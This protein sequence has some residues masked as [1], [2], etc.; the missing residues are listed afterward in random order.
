LPTEE[1][2]L[3][4]RKWED[5]FKGISYPT[6]TV[7]LPRSQVKVECPELRIELEATKRALAAAQ[8]K[9]APEQRLL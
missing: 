7:T 3:E 6:T 5:L 4:G 2:F 9:A 1:F 8:A